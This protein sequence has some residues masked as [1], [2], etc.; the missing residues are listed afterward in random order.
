M[1]TREDYARNAFWGSNS[2]LMAEVENT[3]G[4][5]MDGVWYPANGMTL[6]E[7]IETVESIDGQTWEELQ[8]LGIVE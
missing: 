3:R 2:A 5:E 1:K 6:A 7:C 8:A 4:Y